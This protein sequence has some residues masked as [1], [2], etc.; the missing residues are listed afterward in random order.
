LNPLKT[1]G[2]LWNEYLASKTGTTMIDKALPAVTTPFISATGC[3]NDAVKD[4]DF[5]KYASIVMMGFNDVFSFSTDGHTQFDPIFN[6]LHKMTVMANVL[7]LSLPQ[8]KIEDPRHASWT[9]SGTWANNVNYSYGLT[10]GSAGA[11][12]QKT[13]S[14]VRYIAVRVFYKEGKN[15]DYKIFLNGVQQSSIKWTAPTVYLGNVPEKA[16]ENTCIAQIFDLG[17]VFNSCTVR[18]VNVNAGLATDFGVDFVAGW[19]DADLVN[20][21]PV[22]LLS[23]PDTRELVGAAT[24]QYNR[25]LKNEAMKSV[26]KECRLRGL[27]VAYYKISDA[28]V[29]TDDDNFHPSFRQSEMWADEIL[30][31]AIIL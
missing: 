13:L 12:V 20:A 28:L 7:T 24:S 10:T 17:T 4:P 3:A 9:K 23:I 2:T 11:F 16:Q 27:P 8:A 31:N 6:S 30:K 5:A 15:F 14:S 29:M 19:S 1:W 18:V 21:R 26:A 22:L 25:L